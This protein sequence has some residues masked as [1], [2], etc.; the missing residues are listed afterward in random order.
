MALLG[1]PSDLNSTYLRGPALAPP[2]IR[3]ALACDSANSYAELGESFGE[4]VADHGDVSLAADTTPREADAELESAVAAL[5]RG[6][7]APGQLAP[8]LLGGD[9]SVTFPAFRALASHCRTSL[10][11]CALR[12]LPICIVHFDAHPDLY[13]EVGTFM[14]DENAFS[15][16]SPFARIMESGD[17]AALL[18]LGCRTVNPHQRAQRQKHGVR[19]VDAFAWPD[20]RQG[21]WDWLDSALPKQCLVYIS[22]DTDALDPAFAP[23][24]S[25]YEPGGLSVRNILDVIQS[26][27]PAPPGGWPADDPMPRPQWSVGSQRWAIGADFVEFNVSR[28]IGASHDCD[29]AVTRPG[30]T[31]MV[32]AKLVKELAALLHRS[33]Q[34]MPTD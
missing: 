21:L 26:L 20:T 2:V 34:A 19:S 6:G 1:L 12:Q 22:I 29:G 32:G 3:E 5:L 15:H 8:L 23:G 24:V 13:E 14:P 17:C 16:A 11:P 27:A 33:R 10:Q 31:A 9:H 25:H 7:G 4:I 30:M 18:Q 28:D